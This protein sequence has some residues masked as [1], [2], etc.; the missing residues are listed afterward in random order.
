MAFVID[1]V[2][3]ITQYAAADIPAN[4]NHGVAVAKD[5]ILW[6]IKDVTDFSIS[7]SS[8]TVDATDGTGSII[9]S[10]LRS[11]SAQMTGSNALFSMPLAAAQAGTKV[12]EGAADIDFHDVLKV[13]KGATEVTLSKTPK[14]GGEPVVVYICN[15]DGSLAEKIEIGAA[16]AASYAD[17][18]VTFAES[19]AVDG[20]V[21][22]FVPYTYTEEKATKF[23]NFADADTI[24][25]RVVVEGIGKDV[26]T[27]ALVYFYAIAPYS[28]L[29]LDGDI[30]LGSPD[31]THDFTIDCKKEYCGQEGLYTIITC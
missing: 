25:G 5:D 11:K 9:E 31:A 3:R 13:A 24:P 16:G 26:C 29:T 17:G 12:V 8:E 1:R 22:V 21:E 10:F 28:K 23:T 27:H 30:N 15:T 14:E 18:K 20:E 19:P 7:N 4:E 6:T 2:R